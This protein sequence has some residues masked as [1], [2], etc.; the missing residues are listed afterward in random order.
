MET[1]E[2]NNLSTSS[3]LTKNQYTNENEIGGDLIGNQV[4]DESAVSSMSDVSGVGTKR[5]RKR[6][7]VN[8]STITNVPT[9]TNESIALE[10]HELSRSAAGSKHSKEECLQ[11]CRNKVISKVVDTTLNIQEPKD[12]LTSMN[13]KIRDSDVSFYSPES[14][15]SDDSANINM[16]DRISNIILKNFQKMANPIMFKT[17]R[18]ILMEMKQ[19][20]PQSFQDVCL[21]S[22]VCKYM[23]S[24]NYR[25]TIRRFIQEIFFDLSFNTFNND[26]DL[27]LNVVRQRLTDLNLLDISKTFPPTSSLSSPPSLSTSATSTTTT[28]KTHSIKSP[29]LAS[30]HETSVENLMD[31]SSSRGTQSSAETKTTDEVDSIVPKNNN[32]N[33]KVITDNVAIRSPSSAE[34][35]L[36]PVSMQ[37]VT[38]EIHNESFKI[39]DSEMK[40]YRR[41]R[42]N[43][44]ELD[45]SCT[46]NKFPIRHRSL[47]DEQ[48][49]A[50]STLQRPIRPVSL[51]ANNNNINFNKDSVNDFRK[52]STNN[53]YNNNNNNSNIRNEQSLITK[54][55]S[56][57]DHNFYKSTPRSSDLISPL[58]LPYE[59]LYCEQRLIQSS[60]SDA[61]LSSSTTNKQNNKNI[62]SAK[63]KVSDDGE[64]SHDD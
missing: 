19:K 63:G 10:N 11:C 25:M 46:K 55:F 40:T 27:I 6:P 50:S 33:D 62:D 61:A 9:S 7:I 21:Y 41:R 44:L 56:T 18:K 16:P 24:C 28:H 5:N 64:K 13:G 39:V 17:C 4:P 14:I 57:S 45:L 37:K 29:L 15:V 51:S 35:K 1:L 30:V 59:P 32:N 22:E 8:N 43:T 20:Y 49:L 53:S 42:F 60:R 47:Q 48:P 58:S 31:S 3:I 52:T 23:G 26:V 34:A 38:A 2:S 36:S 54:S 12:N